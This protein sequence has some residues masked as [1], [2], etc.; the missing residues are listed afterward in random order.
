MADPQ[1]QAIT[2]AQLEPG[3]DG[4]QDNLGGRMARPGAFD[5]AALAGFEDQPLEWNAKALVMS[6]ARHQPPVG[7]DVDQIAGRLALSQEVLETDVDPAAGNLTTAEAERCKRL[8][9][10]GETSRVDQQ[11]EVGRAVHRF[12][13]ITVGLPMAPRHVVVVESLDQLMS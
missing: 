3:T 2:P 4:E 5:L 12:G 10:V 7:V 13:E 8:V 9:H 11:V 1:A 6:L